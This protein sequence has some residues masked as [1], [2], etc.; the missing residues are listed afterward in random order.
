MATDPFLTRKSVVWLAERVSLFSPHTIIALVITSN[1]EVL[2]KQETDHILKDIANNFQVLICNCIAGEEY[3]GYQKSFSCM[4]YIH[5][6]ELSCFDVCFT[7]DYEKDCNI[8]I[9]IDLN[10]STLR[11]HV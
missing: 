2:F 5:T 6:K 8:G 11:A 1:Q 3:L 4:T 10:R 9:I 7:D